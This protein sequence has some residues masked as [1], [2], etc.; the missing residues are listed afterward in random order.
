[1]AT[2][3]TKR[4][5]P[6]SA[7]GDW[8]QIDNH[9][10]CA[11][12]GLTPRQMIAITILLEGGSREEAAAAA[13]VHRNTILNWLKHDVYFK[14]ALDTGKFELYVA[15]YDALRSAASKGI[16]VLSEMA[17]DVTVDSG[18]RWQAAKYLVDK[19]LSVDSSTDVPIPDGAS[20]E[21][22]NYVARCGAQSAKSDRDEFHKEL[23]AR[24]AASPPGRELNVVLEKIEKHKS[25]RSS[26]PLNRTA[27]RAYTRLLDRRNELLQLKKQYLGLIPEGGDA[28]PLAYR[29]ATEFMELERR[30]RIPP[31]AESDDEGLQRR[32]VGGRKRTAEI[33]ANRL[34]AALDRAER[35]TGTPSTSSEPG[36]ELRN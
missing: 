3:R 35:E 19:S 33:I 18:I 10:S 9:S 12:H 2:K 30:Q 27:L 28:I 34:E 5:K 13:R 31:E 15:Q 17:A 26:R 14:A 6:R 8:S 29:V 16:R 23:E 32:L 20:I 36:N 11:S 25:R 22:M 1:M 4:Q 21:T 7:N 24:F